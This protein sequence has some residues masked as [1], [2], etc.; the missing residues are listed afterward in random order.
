MQAQMKVERSSETSDAI[1]APANL[2]SLNPEP[3]PARAISFWRAF[4]THGLSPHNGPHLAAGRFRDALFASLL[5]GAILIAV[6]GLAAIHL[7]TSFPLTPRGVRSALAIALLWTMDVSQQSGPWSHVVTLAFLLSPLSISLSA[8]LLG[9]FAAPIAAAGDNLRSTIRRSINDAL[10]TVVALT[11]LSLLIVTMIVAQQWAY[12]ARTRN[13]V[14]TFFQL[15]FHNRSIAI[16]SAVAGVVLLVRAIRSGTGRYVGPAIGPG[17]EPRQTHCEDCGYLLGGLPLTSNCPECGLAVTES[18]PG[19]RRASL[20]HALSR[21]SFFRPFAYLDVWSRLWRQHASVLRVP[22]TS[23][24]TASR[25]WWIG[26][27]YAML[28]VVSVFTPLWYHAEVNRDRSAVAV[29]SLLLWAV[30]AWPFVQYLME[31]IMCV[32]GRVMFDIR[33]IRISAAATRFAAVGAGPLLPLIL[34]QT[35]CMFVPPFRGTMLSFCGVR[36]E[37]IGVP[38]TILGVIAALVIVRWIRR[39]VDGLKSAAIANS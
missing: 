27:A 6:G 4:L 25:F 29:V 36:F 20:T 24:P 30:T 13:T 33:D 15:A 38:S 14:L 28:I 23:F 18:L 17:F 39:C 16:V 37:V 5:A 11:P 26:Y 35:I 22:M 19:G 7:W 9:L 1:C 34:L 12:A 10:W 2:P 21:L 8:I 3:E 32:V 31:I